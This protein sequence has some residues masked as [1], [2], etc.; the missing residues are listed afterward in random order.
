MAGSFIT[1]SVVVLYYYT[2]SP[3]TSLSYK[4]STFKIDL[5][6]S[7]CSSCLLDWPINYEVTITSGNKTS[8]IK[9]E[10]ETPRLIVAIDKE[11]NS[12]LFFGTTSDLMIYSKELNFERINRALLLNERDNSLHIKLRNFKPAFKVTNQIYIELIDTSL[13]L[14][15]TLE[16]LNKD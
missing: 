2:Y 7:E 12:V 15:S 8:S 13:S 16:H 5:N 6:L 1:V 3:T 10:T 11:K 9:F 4:T 14:Q